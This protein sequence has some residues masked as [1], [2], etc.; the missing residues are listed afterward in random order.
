VFTS[1]YG[2]MVLAKAVAIVL[3]GSIG[4]CHRRRTL[5]ALA[6]GRRRAFVRLA[7]GE[8]L[9]MAAAMGLAVGL[10]RTPAPAAGDTSLSP[11]EELL[12]FPM[13]PPLGDFPWT[14]LFTQWHFDPLFAFGTAAA[15]LLYLAGVPLG[16]GLCGV[17]HVAWAAA[18]VHL[19]ERT[20]T[21]GRG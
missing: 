18:S 1:R 12:G 2:L 15:A 14:P 9:L 21:V 8:L 5:P 19:G 16:Q 4:H 6:E 20:A 11:S 10:S 13:P 3:L 7:A 17:R